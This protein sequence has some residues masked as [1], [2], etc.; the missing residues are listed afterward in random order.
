MGKFI[1]ALK[2]NLYPKVGTVK[3][4]FDWYDYYVMNLWD[5]NYIRGL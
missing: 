3:L 5:G 4:E 2:L 1:T